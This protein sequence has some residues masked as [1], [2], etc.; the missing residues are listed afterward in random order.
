MT[1]HPSHSHLSNEGFGDPSIQCDEPTTSTVHAWW[2]RPTLG[3]SSQAFQIREP[4]YTFT[5]RNNLPEL[6]RRA[7]LCRANIAGDG[8][9]Q[10][11]IPPQ[12]IF[13][14]ISNFLNKAY[15]AM[16]LEPSSTTAPLVPRAQGQRKFMGIPAFFFLPSLFS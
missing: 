5:L 8:R 9:A 4:I 13:W 1:S 7:E 11:P 14:I 16:S 10:S 6:S 3:H 15:L 12:S 2:E